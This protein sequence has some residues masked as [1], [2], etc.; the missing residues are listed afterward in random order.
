[1]KILITGACGFLARVLARELESSPLRHELVLLDRTRPED[2]TV[3][4]PG[5]HER[6]L[7]PWTTT[8]PFFL[9]EITDPGA[10]RVALEGVDAIIHLAAAVSGLPE[11]G[12]D[13]FHVNSCGTF[14]VLD[15]ARRA[16]V[17]RFLC[18]SSVNAFG[19][20][21][22]RLSGAPVVY[23]ALPLTEQFAPIPEDAYSLSKLVNEHTC[24]AFSRAYGLTT[25]AFRFAGVWGAAMFEEK[26]AQPLPA[27]QRWEDN[28]YSWV[29]IADIARGLRQA[30]ECQTLPKHGVYTLGA[31]DTT[32]PEP[33]MEVLH[34][35]RPDL[36]ATL[37][38]P[39]VGREPL[40]SIESARR[41][42]G[43]EPQ[44]RLAT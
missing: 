3:F 23:H 36:A 21:H 12:V 37:P 18:A 11:F 8:H 7:E 24:A 5:S 2:S 9:G 19:T 27:T 33:T 26:A 14:V 6:A 20:F 30:V 16:G 41:A 25:A 4:V 22:W 34:R 44:F 40:L 15:E 35:F 13:T 1:M 39:F 43:Y 31:G 42:F 10:V 17:S 29:H 38:R 28:L 32:C